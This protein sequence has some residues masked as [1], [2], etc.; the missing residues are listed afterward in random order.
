MQRLS[1][2]SIQ[3]REY[4][5]KHKTDFDFNLGS[6]QN[7]SMRLTPASIWLRYNSYPMGQ[8]AAR[9]FLRQLEQPA[10]P[11]EVRILQTRLVIRQRDRAAG[12]AA[13]QEHLPACISGFLKM[14]NSFAKLFT[15][16]I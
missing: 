6:G 8:E 2:Q 11:P 1:Y 9:M 4:S 7:Q 3:Q 10:A 13:R 12:E 15:G 5:I 16:V 14:R